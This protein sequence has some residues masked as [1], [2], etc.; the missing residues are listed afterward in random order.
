[1]VCVHR[2]TGRS[3]EKHEADSTAAFP[4]RDI[5]WTQLNSDPIIIYSNAAEQ[6]PTDG[7]LKNGGYYP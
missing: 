4:S 6:E 3:A 1:V 7:S 2:Q 5:S